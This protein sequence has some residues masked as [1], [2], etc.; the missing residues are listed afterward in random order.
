M[1][2]DTPKKLPPRWERSP[3]GVFDVYANVSHITW[4]LE[5]IRIR[6]G[7]LVASPEARTPGKD[8]R[9][10]AEERAA[11]TFSWRAAVLLRDQLTLLIGEFE[12]ENGPIRLDIKLPKA[13]F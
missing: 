7:Q 12:K 6:L 11:V 5:D 1:A 9:S 10:V 3:N 2:D 13:P 4:T 8:Y